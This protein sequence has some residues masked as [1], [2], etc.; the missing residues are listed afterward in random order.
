MS[1]LRATLGALSQILE[2][3]TLTEVGKIAEEVLNYLRPAFVL[4]PT[5]TVE[6]VQQLLKC[7]FGTNLTANISEISVPSSK[8][9]C[10]DEN[11][12]SITLIP[13]FVCLKHFCMYVYFL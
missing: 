2:I 6:C 11:E 7:L 13:V 4:E 9:D 5:G 1:L 3:A 10:D 12:V 8:L